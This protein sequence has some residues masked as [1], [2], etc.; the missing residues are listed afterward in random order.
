MAMTELGLLFI[1]TLATMATLGIF[2]DFRDSDGAPDRATSVLVAFL[3]G[4]LWAVFAVSSNDVIVRSSSVA[5]SSEPI[6]PLFWL[7]VL[8]AMLVGIY[9]IYSLLKAFYAETAGT[10]DADVELI[11]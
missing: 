1:G 9:A 2:V 6:E 7:G 5:T 3:G 11:Q 10:A 4:V 8:M